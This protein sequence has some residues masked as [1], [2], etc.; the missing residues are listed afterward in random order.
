MLKYH[1]IYTLHNKQR[2]P[3][4]ELITLTTPFGSI[5]HAYILL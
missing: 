1:F 2:V 4:E 5:V 3:S